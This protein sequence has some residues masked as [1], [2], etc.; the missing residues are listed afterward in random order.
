MLPMIVLLVIGILALHVS[1]G[2]SWHNGVH[3]QAVTMN[4]GASTP[5]SSLARGSPVLMD[6]RSSQLST[7]GSQSSYA[8]SKNGI[9]HKKNARSCCP[10]TFPN[11]AL[12]ELCALPVTY[13]DTWSR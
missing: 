12:A 6:Y 9:R 2:A 10:A 11:F 1:R 8:T 7:V 4:L 13:Q 3:C 5:P